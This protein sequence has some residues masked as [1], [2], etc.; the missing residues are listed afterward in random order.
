M[1]ITGF[2]TVFI[3]R[4]GLYH[5]HAPSHLQVLIAYMKTVFISVAKAMRKRRL[6]VK[7]FSRTNAQMTICLGEREKRTE[8]SVAKDRGFYVRL[9]TETPR[10]RSQ[11]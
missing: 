6:S 2:V 11:F 5:A 10:S 1:T 4:H 7:G 8:N 9:H 3:F